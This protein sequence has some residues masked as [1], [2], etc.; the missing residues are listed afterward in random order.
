MGGGL[1]CPPLLAI[2]AD[3][4]L[5]LRFCAHWLRRLVLALLNTRSVWVMAPSSWSTRW[6]LAALAH[7]W[8]ARRPRRSLWARFSRRVARCPPITRGRSIS[9]WAT[10]SA[11]PRKAAKRVEGMMGSIGLGWWWGVSVAPRVLIIADRGWLSRVGSQFPNWHS[12]AVGD[13][14]GAAV[15]PGGGRAETL[16]DLLAVLL[17][18]LEALGVCCHRHLA[19]E[20][21]AGSFVGDE[22]RSG[23]C[24]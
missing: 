22:H 23:V 5:L 24:G 14:P 4:T 13:V 18:C 19:G 10:R 1:E 3:Q 21:L 6:R 7:A 8:R 2:L 12:V 16:A 15:A 20:V 9:R 11:S 17:L